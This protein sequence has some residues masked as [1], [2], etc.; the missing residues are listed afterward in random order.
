MRILIFLLLFT[1][2]SVLIDVYVYRNWRRFAHWRP[3]FK[4]TLP[5]FLIGIFLMPLVMPTYAWLSRWWEVEP[6]LMRQAIISLWA[7]WYIPKVPIVIGLLIKDIVA[8][9]SRLFKP[10]SPTEPSPV[11][12]DITE[13]PDLTRRQFLQKVGWTSATVPF[14]VVGYGLMR[15]LYDFQVRHVEIAV[16]N[17][18]Q[19]FHGLRIAQISD[20]HAGSLFSERPMEHA[21]ETINAQ[22]PDLIMITGDFVN[23][24][25]R[26]APVILPAISRLSAELGVF[27]VRGN[28]D[29]YADVGRVS[30]MIR[31][32]G[33]NLLV[34]DARTLAIDGARL[35][36]IGTDNTG[37]GQ[38]HA[39]LP[40]ALRN[41]RPNGEDAR[42]LMTHDP[43]FWD[44]AREIAP[45]IDL[46]L[47]GHTHGGQFGFELGPL[48]WSLARLVYQRWA[49]LYTED[50][51]TSLQQLYIN[52]GLATV[53]PPLRLGIRPEITILTLVRRELPTGP[54]V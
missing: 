44:A 17:L 38:S 51:G 30:A 10:K 25:H 50:S 5:V 39:D 52:R 27:A 37:F 53:G 28:H 32:A 15:D 16:P 19:A 4:W 45:E 35:H 1:L 24:D 12:A 2:F 29:H 21:V 6:K 18:P 31:D 36:I 8:F 26:E 11:G 9:S 41:T 33:V 20:L 49:G 48:R 47:S 13:L 7:I 3:K 54:I 22:R 34:N 46:T 43:T 23:N 40:A 14:A 42:I